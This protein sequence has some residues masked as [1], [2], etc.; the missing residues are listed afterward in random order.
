MCKRDLTVL[1]WDDMPGQQRCILSRI[2]I[3]TE[4]SHSSV[5]P[6]ADTAARQKWHSIGLNKA[7]TSHIPGKD[8]PSV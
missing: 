2:V 5:W 7:I 8:Y 1:M 3:K 6:D 4:Y